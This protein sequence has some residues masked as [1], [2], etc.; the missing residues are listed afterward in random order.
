MDTSYKL[1]LLQFQ[2]AYHLVLSNAEVAE[3]QTRFYQT[4]PQAP[5]EVMLI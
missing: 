2:H 5:Q 4:Y 1:H 3:L